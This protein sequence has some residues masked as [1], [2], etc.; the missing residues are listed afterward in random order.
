MARS[1]DATMA[2]AVP[3]RDHTNVGELAE[4]LPSTPATHAGDDG[5]GLSLEGRFDAVS[6][7]IL[8]SVL[9]CPSC[10]HARQKIMPTDACQDFYEYT[11]AR[12]C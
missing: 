4:P 9:N 6:T 3:G 7:V 11:G 10:G 8:E 1:G 2:N 12:H 5:S